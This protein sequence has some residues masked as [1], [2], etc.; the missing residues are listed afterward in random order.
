M[1]NSERLHTWVYLN[2]VLEGPSRVLHAL[3]TAG[4]SPEKI[5]AGIRH[6]EQWVGELSRSAERRAHFCEEQALLRQAEQLQTRFICPDDPEWPREQ[7]DR[8][9]GFAASGTSEHLRSYAADAVAPHGLW[10]RGGDLSAAV[11]RSVAIVGTRAMSSYGQRASEE[12]SRQLAEQH[13]TIISGAALGVDT[14]AHT[15]ALDAGGCTVAVGAHGAG[16][17]YPA[18]NTALIER[19]VR[20]GGCWVSEYPPLTPPARHRFLTRNRL[21]AAL[22]AGTVVVEAGW[23]SGALNTLAWAQGLGAVAMAVPGPITG[24]G[25]LGCHDKIKRGDAQ[26]VVSAADIM[27]LV[28]RIGEVDVDGQCELAFPSDPIQQLS[29]N[30]LKVYDSLPCRSDQS[31]TAAQVAESAGLSVAL[32]VHLLVELQRRGLAHRDGVN[33]AKRISGKIK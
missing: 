5:A 12:I 9:F 11:A 3:L 33:W 1:T 27:G 15:A 24:A 26:L 23:R 20:S 18:K 14:A 4:H 31:R 19:I 13:W 8:A 22:S 6:G 7:L 28:G 21:V 10:V 25:S 29:R 2:Y 30:E 32:T 17:C 16:R